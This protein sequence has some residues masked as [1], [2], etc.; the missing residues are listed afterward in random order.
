MS[1]TSGDFGGAK[2]GTGTGGYKRFFAWLLSK[3]QDHYPEDIDRRK[4]QLLAEVAGRVVEVGAGAGANIPLY[5]DGVELWLVE[6][7]PYMHAYL[8][9]SA[10]REGRTFELR[11]GSAEHMDVPDG[12]AD[13]VVCTLVL[14]SVADPAAAVREID[15][16]LRPG[17]VFLF[18]EHVAAPPGS[19]LRRWQSLLRRP[20]R[21]VGDGC[22]LDR[23]T[24]SVIEAAGFAECHIE[25]FAA[26]GLA[27]V[28]PHI[29]GRAVKAR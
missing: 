17:G 7:N 22:T 27:L 10:S 25:R 9:E 6:P 26:E 23:E 2:S 20:W 18:L 15:R 3:L 29:A 13:F 5:P 16:V 8:R 28:R 12:A 14:C 4:R 19:R 1:E 11:Q 21:A 24:W